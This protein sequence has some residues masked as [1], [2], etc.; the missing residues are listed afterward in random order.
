M[1]T[2]HRC[3]GFTLVSAIFLIV[4][5]AA[6]GIYMVTISG[7]QHA[8]TSHAAVAAR[9]YYSAKSGLEWAMHRTVNTVLSES[10]P[11]P[12]P[13]AGFCDCFTNPGTATT[14]LTPITFSLSG[15]A[16]D[17]IGVRVICKY[18][19]HKEGGGSN[20]PFN[21]YVITSE[22]EYSAFGAPDYARRRIEAT[23][24]NRY[25]PKE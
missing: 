4:A 5:L 2:K 24:S 10:G 11:T 22:A 3:A 20:D 25:G 15:D 18:S 8:T 7:V 9:V 14:T 1:S 6:L 12:C 17:G 16:L 21:V 13:E 19:T 23:V